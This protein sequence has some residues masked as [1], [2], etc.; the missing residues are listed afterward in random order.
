MVKNHWNILSIISDFGY[1]GCEFRSRVIKY[2]RRSLYTLW[3][4]KRPY[5]VAGKR[6]HLRQCPRH[7][8]ELKSL[9]RKQK[10]ISLLSDETSSNRTYH[11]NEQFSLH[12]LD[13][14]SQVWTKLWI[15]IQYIEGWELLI[16]QNWAYALRPLSVGWYL[17]VCIKT[18]PRATFLNLGWINPQGVNGVLP[19]G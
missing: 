8:L 19:G 4:E 16:P 10:H 7:R 18:T 15:L 3:L 2:I 17:G 13:R 11:D 6:N 1:I 5:L 14:M 9:R 12:F